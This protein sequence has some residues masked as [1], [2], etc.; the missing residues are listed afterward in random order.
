MTTKTIKPSGGDYT[1]YTAWLATLPATL[2]APEQ[3]DLYN[4]GSGG[5]VESLGLTLAGFT[6][7]AT[8]KF[9]FNV[10]SGER[11]NGTAH[12][13]AYL[14]NGAGSI[15]GTFRCGTDYVELNWLEIEA[16]NGQNAIY[17]WGSGGPTATN[18]LTKIEHCLV[19]SNS[20]VT[21]GSF[22]WGNYNQIHRN[23]IS[24]VSGASRMFDVRGITSCEVSN[25]LFYTQ[26]GD[27]PFLLDTSGSVVKNTYV[28]GASSQ[29]FWSGSSPSGNNNA[30]SDT[31]ATA[32]F[33]SSINSIAG[34]TAFTSVTSGSED[35]RTKSGFTGLTDFGATLAAITDDC[36]GT[37][38]PQGSAYDIGPFENGGGGGGSTVRR[39]MAA[40]GVG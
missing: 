33:S 4:F 16:L 27:F 7:S 28:G 13:G 22:N 1:S 18:N 29:C 32:Q 3:S 12:S 30:S 40:M 37:A 36:V 39:S 24:Y 23:N 35:F 10:P 26:G 2:I 17:G 21:Y 9:I 5:L 14:T 11:H 8:N 25:C 20:A 31:T 6:T 19:H 34:A 15:F 38:R